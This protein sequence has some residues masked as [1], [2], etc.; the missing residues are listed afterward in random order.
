VRCRRAPLLRSWRACRGWARRARGRCCLDSTRRSLLLLLLLLLSLPLLALLLLLLPHGNEC[1]VSG[2]AG[3]RACGTDYASGMR[4]P[5][6]SCPTSCLHA[7]RRVRR[8]LW[9]ALACA[10]AGWLAP[11]WP[12]RPQQICPRSMVVK[13]IAGR[14]QPGGER[15][16]THTRIAAAFNTP[17]PTVA[18]HH[19]TL[20]PSHTDTAVHTGA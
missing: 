4:M 18:R 16:G 5:A 19:L 2:V 15:F 6:A 9:Q 14:G 10:L 13:R 3:V 11:Q 8:A 17:S 7:S 20:P 12:A 1:V